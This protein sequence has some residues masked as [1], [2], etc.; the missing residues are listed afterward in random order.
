MNSKANLRDYSQEIDN[1][2]FKIN[3]D[4]F[5]IKEGMSEIREEVIH[6]LKLL[7]RHYKQNY[8]QSSTLNYE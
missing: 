8:Q 3:V 2:G 6:I 5:K 7:V 1:K 4:G